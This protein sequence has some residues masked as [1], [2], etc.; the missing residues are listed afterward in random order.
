MASVR[1]I[2]IKK[3][4]DKNPILKGISLEIADGE[5]VVLVGPS[6]C[7]KST[8]LRTLA[9]LEIPDSGEIWIGDRRVDS[10]EPR[11]RNIAMVF[12]SYALYPHMN[13]KANLAFAL[14]LRGEA[15][16]GIDKRV[17]EVASMLGIESFL[18]RYPRQLS[19]G[20]RQRV[21]MGRALVREADVFLLDEP[22]SNLDAALRTQTRVEIK[23]LHNK[24][25]AT[26]IY[27]THDQVEAMTMAD[28]LVVLR[29]GEIMQVGSPAD[30]YDRPANAFVATFLGSPPMN[31]LRCKVDGTR[32]KSEGIDLPCPQEARSHR[33]VIVGLRPHDLIASLDEAAGAG[34]V[35]E[36][37]GTVFATVDAIEPLGWDANV[38]FHVSVEKI[39]ARFEASQARKLREG[40]GLR[41]RVP[42]ASAHIFEA[43]TEQ[44]ICHG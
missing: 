3:A 23:K 19:G 4:L 6:G 11:D 29:A 44:A 39:V 36:G 41:L 25:K 10:L 24:L 5:L 32:I 28:R 20:Q 40:Q 9:G 43:T 21:A 34:A 12:Q 22:L 30:L 31:L 8:L 27:V 38:H 26:M 15:E 1:I 33:D 7:G 16:A 2:D 18:E 35:E 17:R 13:V 42:A 37:D 14:K